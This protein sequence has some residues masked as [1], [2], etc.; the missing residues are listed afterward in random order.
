MSAQSPEEILNDI[1][2]NLRTALNGFIFEPS[3]DILEKRFI[4]RVAE[5]V[6]AHV[7]EMAKQHLKVTRIGDE[8]I[9][10][11]GKPLMDIVLSVY[12]DDIVSILAPNAAITLP[13]WRKPDRCDSVS[14]QE[15]TISVPLP[16]IE[17]EQPQPK[18]VRTRPRSR[19][20]WQGD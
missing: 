5:V 9:L 15:Q 3:Q 16:D 1:N 20:I 4:D 11:L 18:V 12:G 6:G 7:H 19:R 14:E 17:E 10:E 13:G 8:I 2:R